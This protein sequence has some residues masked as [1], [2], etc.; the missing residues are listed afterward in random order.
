MNDMQKMLKKMVVAVISEDEN[1]EE[2]TIDTRIDE[3]SKFPVYPRKKLMKCVQLLSQSFLL[4][5]IREF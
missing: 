4:N 2:R 3:L 5:W 1:L